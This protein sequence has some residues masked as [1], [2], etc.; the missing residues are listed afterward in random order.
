MAG[1]TNYTPKQ[2]AELN[3][4]KRAYEKFSKRMRTAKAKGDTEY[5]E[6]SLKKRNKVTEERAV[7]INS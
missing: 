4:L 3:R 2:E 6:A 5:Y 1:K 7:I